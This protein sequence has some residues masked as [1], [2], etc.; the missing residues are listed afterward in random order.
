MWASMRVLGCLDK[1]TEKHV[2]VNWRALVVFETSR[3]ASDQPIQG[4]CRHKCEKVRWQAGVQRLIKREQAYGD[5]LPTAN[6]G[7]LAC[8]KIHLLRTFLN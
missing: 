7:K 4:E 6:T 5:D 2:M 1:R 8:S 3:R